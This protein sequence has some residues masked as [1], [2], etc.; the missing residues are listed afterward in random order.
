MLSVQDAP[1]E[2]LLAELGRRWRTRPADR[3]IHAAIVVAVVAREHGFA[4][5]DLR[6]PARHRAV[7]HARHL[8]MACVLRAGGSYREAAAAVN[9]N[10]HQSAKWAEA[11]VEQQAERNAWTRQ[12]LENLAA[13]VRAALEAATIS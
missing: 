4:P 12:E 2:S 10:C 7:A 3:S 8:A 5:A 1:T 11:K 9:R 6:G 13:K